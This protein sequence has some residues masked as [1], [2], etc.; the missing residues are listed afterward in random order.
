VA[1]RESSNRDPY[2]FGE[3]QK[4]KGWSKPVKVTAAPAAVLRLLTNP[5]PGAPVGLC[6]APLMYRVQPSEGGYAQPPQGSAQPAPPHGYAQ[7]VPA[8]PAQ[9]AQPVQPVQPVQPSPPM[10]ND[11]YFMVA[12]PTGSVAEAYEGMP[13]KCFQATA[14]P[15]PAQ[16]PQVHVAYAGEA[17]WQPPTWQ[18]PPQEAQM[19]CLR[20]SEVLSVETSNSNGTA[21]YT[22]SPG[23]QPVE[24]P[25]VP[26]EG[27]RQRASSE[28]STASGASGSAEDSSK[29]PVL[30]SAALP[31]RG[32]ALHAWRACKPC[33]FV[34]Q[35]G[36]QN[37]ELC[38]FCHLCEPGERKRRKKERRIQKRE[39]SGVKVCQS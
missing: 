8:Q 23:Y 38:D 39:S 22:V 31:S 19:P 7:P 15:V 30:G 29:S 37:K 13:S 24:T 21:S 28:Y 17:T 20:L 3:L 32:S 5:V 2:Q 18:Q 16:P 12:T 1:N 25:K 26:T 33:A 6:R 4:R 27:L 34:F 9:P 36:C 11:G 14:T 35:E 10:S